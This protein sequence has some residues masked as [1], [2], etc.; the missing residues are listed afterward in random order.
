MP[1]NWGRV[2]G[3]LVAALVAATFFAARALPLGLRAVLIFSLARITDSETFSKIA[4]SFAVVETF[5]YLFD[6]GQDTLSVKLLSRS[7]L[8]WLRALRLCASLKVLSWA[9]GLGIN[10]ILVHQFLLPNDASM[11]LMI[12]ALGVCPLFWNLPINVMQARGVLRA[13]AAKIWLLAL[14]LF[15]CALVS[16]AAEAVPTVLLGYVAIEYVGLVLLALI[17]WRSQTFSPKQWALSKRFT[18]RQIEAY[19][20]RGGT[21]VVGQM[22]A[23]FYG[24]FDVLLVINFAT[25]ATV[26]SYLFAQRI[27]DLAGFLSGGVS[28]VMYSTMVRIASTDRVRWQLSARRW[29]VLF[30]IIAVTIGLA[31]WVAIPLIVV[32][33]FANMNDARQYIVLFGLVALFAVAN[34]FSSGLLNAVGRFGVIARLNIFNLCVLVSLGTFA[35]FYFGVTTM[36]GVIAA[37]YAVSAVIQFQLVRKSIASANP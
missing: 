29:A 10:F 37:V 7:G 34:Q 12:A 11:A 33:F 9:V 31:F 24:K 15:V 35:F 36:I 14:V 27:V 5:R 19:G 4:S 32:R 18:R 1:A 26:A 28:S 6:W 17:A 21:V 2:R 30:G 22:A 13:N 16:A 8:L 25:P 3:Q 20:H 23:L